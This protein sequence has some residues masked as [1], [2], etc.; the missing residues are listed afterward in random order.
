MSALGTLGSEAGTLLV[1]DAMEDE[2]QRVRQDA[3]VALL[4]IGSPLA[5]PALERAL[6]DEDF[7][8]RL[9]AAEA[10]KRIPVAQ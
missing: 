3:V 4:R 7:E 8:V 9:Y 1:L 2:A 10:L 6:T 5:R